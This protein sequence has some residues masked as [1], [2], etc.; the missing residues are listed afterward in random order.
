MTTI[1]ADATERVMA[2]DAFWFSSD[3]CGL[4]KKVFRVR[5]ALVGAAGDLREIVRW[6]EAYRKKRDLPD[7]LSIT[8]LRLSADGLHTWTAADGWL[9]VDE[10]RYAIGSGGKCARGAMAAG[11]SC[12][13]AVR[14]AATIDAGTGGPVRTYRLKG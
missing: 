8:V 6:L 12:R 11:A 5:G 10:P 13:E 14:I 7:D 1:A 4:V 9:P 3:E 2:C